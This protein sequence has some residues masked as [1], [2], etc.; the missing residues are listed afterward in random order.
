[1]IPKV[2]F[3]SIKTDKALGPRRASAGSLAQGLRIARHVFEIDAGERDAELMLGIGHRR[4][5]D[6]V[7][8]V[9]T[10]VRL[11][12]FIDRTGGAQNIVG[13]HAPAVAGEFVAAARTA[14][15]AQNAATDQ[16]LQNR[17]EMPR[18]QAMARGEC[19]CGDWLS[20]LLHRDINDR[21]NSE[22]SF[23]RKQWHRA[24]ETS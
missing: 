3:D 23:A 9:G 22:N 17:F 24:L 4:Q 12:G 18:R 1:M 13:G 7:Q 5:H 14:D 10:G 15:A 11:I 6:L 21:G 8:E 20:T 2:G 19:F 16:S